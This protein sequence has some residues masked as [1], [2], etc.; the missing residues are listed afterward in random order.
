M[1]QDLKHIIHGKSHLQIGKG[2]LSQGIINEIIQLFKKNKFLKIRFLDLGEFE[3]IESAVSALS[4]K[5]KVK[6]VD[7]RGNTVVLRK[8]SRI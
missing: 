1:D 5:L 3:T 7:I 4:S 8:G 2:G 6:A